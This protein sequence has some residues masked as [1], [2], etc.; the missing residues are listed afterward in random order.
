MWRIAKGAQENRS[1]IPLMTDH[2]G[3][4]FI[5]A[6]LQRSKL[7]TAE[8]FK[9]AKEQG[10]SIALVQEPYVGRNGY[11]KD[12]PG[13]Q[14]IQ[15]TLNRQKPVKAAVVVFGDK[16]EVIHD[17]QLVTETEAAVFLI[18][19]KL[20]LGVVSVYFEGNEDIEPY[21]ARTKA[22]CQKIP[23]Q[24]ILVGGDVN[25][26]SHWWGSR[27]E[28]RRGEAY[29]DFLN[30]MD[31]E[32][33][34]EG[35]TPTFETCRGDRLCTSV[36]DVTACSQSLLG[37]V[38][39]WRVNRGLTTSDHNAI[40]FTLRLEEH[41]ESLRSTST[42]RYNTKKAKWSQ[43]TTQFRTALAEKN[44]TPQVIS[45]LKTK[46]NLEI[47]IEAYMKSIREACEK[48][49]PK[50]GKKKGKAN[51]PWWT[52]ALEEQRKDVLRKKRR[53][54]N[55]APTRI[56]HVYETY[57]LAKDRYAEMAEKAQTNSWKELCSTQEKESMWDGIYRV[58][59]KTA[60][61]REEMLLRSAA[62]ETLSPAQSAQLLA[63]TFYPDDSVSTDKPC[64]T[65][66]RE[67]TEGRKVEEIEGL[68]EDD[69]PFTETE[70]ESV[71]QAQN[72]K[73][74]PGADGFTAD[75][76]IMAIR[77]EKEVFMALANKCLSLTHFPS[78]W[79]TA[80]VII[81]RKPGK[82]DYT[83]PKSYRPIGL[84]SVLGKIV[85]KLM[86][87]RLQ[88]H[89]L[90]TLNSRQ[91]GFTPQRGTEDALY[92][93]MRHVKSEVENRKIVIIVS[94]DIEGAFDNAWWP[95]LK[96]QLRVRKCPRNLY[97]M[98]DSYLSD[99][100]IVV[101]YARAASGK[102]TTKGCVQ[103]S[104]GG[105]TFWNI[106]LDP[107][108]QKLTG[109]GV[110]CQA[111]ADD[112][113][114]VF[115]DKAVSN[116][117]E[118]INETLATVVDWG[119]ENKLNFA[120][121]KTNAML[122]TKKLKFDTPTLHMSGS[123]LS[124]V[125]EIK[126]LGLII[127]R[128]L[129]FKPHVT[130]VCKKAAD[131]YKQLACAAKVTWGLNGEI[132]RTIYVAVIEP[133]V[134][135]AASAWSQA[136][137]LQMII[138]RLNALQRGFAQ[139]ICKAYRTVSLTS[140]LVLSGL[141]PLD[142]R[143][144][145]AASLYK[146]KKGLTKDYLP[147]GRELEKR[148]NYLDFPHPS[149]LVSTEYELIEDMNDQILED[150]HVAG[151]CIYTDGSKIDGNVG[152]ACTWWNEGMES[153]HALYSLHPSCTVFQSEM[154]AL[155][156]AVEMV[157]TNRNENVVTIL[158]DSRS[159]LDLL[160]N[161]KS[162]H[163]LSKTIKESIQQ[164]RAEGRQVRLCWLRAHVGTAGNERADE[165]AKEAALQASDAPDYD[166]VP[167]SYVKRKI[168][169]ES[170]RKWQ[171]RYDFSSTGSVTKVFF[172]NVD[173]AYRI[174]RKTK[175]TPRHVQ[176]LTGHGGM[177]EYLHRFKLCSSPG[178]ECDPEIIESV[179]HVLLE[180][181]RFSAARRE[182]EIQIDTTL[183]KSELQNI[184]AAAEKRPYFLEFV[185]K[186]IRTTSTRTSTM[187]PPTPTTSDTT[188]L[189]Q[190]LPAV[191]R[192]HQTAAAFE[193]LECGERGEP[194]LR[195]RG[196]ATFMDCNSEK[197]GICFCNARAPWAV[198]ISPGLASL[199][200]GSTFR[201]TMKKKTYEALPSALVGSHRC[202]ILRT[203][204]K[205]IALFEPSEVDTEFARACLLLS[206][207]GREDGKGPRR[208]SVD[209]MVVGYE[210]GEV[211]DYMGAVRASAY[212]EV[213]MYEDRGQD[214]SFLKPG[215]LA[216][217]KPPER[218]GDPMAHHQ[219]L[220]GSAR[221][222]EKAAAEE[223]AAKEEKV[224]QSREK[225][226]ELQSKLKNVTEALSKAVLNIPEV[227]RTKVGRLAEA[228]GMAAAVER[229]TKPRPEKVTS[230]KTRNI[231][232]KAD[233][234]IVEPPSLRRVTEPL[235]H[236]VNAFLEY[237][238][239]IVATKLVNTMTCKTIM[240]AYRRKNEGLLQ[241]LL[242]EAEAAV[243]DNRNSQVLKGE[244]RGSYMAAYSEKGGFVALDEEETKRRGR[245]T[246]EAP[247]DDPE[248]VT[249]KCTK[250]ML[251]DRILEMAEKISG[252]PAE[253]GVFAHWAVPK[254]TWVNGVPGCGKTTWVIQNFDVKRDLIITNTT[255]AAL[256]L[257]EKLAT[258]TNANVR[259]A[260][261]T[262]ASIL[263]NG[264]RS[265]EKY[266]RLLVDEALM[267]HFGAIVMA[268]RAA[269]VSETLLIGDN[270][271]LPF[272][273]RNNLFQLAYSQPNL[274][275]T[276]DH[277]LLC[278]HRNPMDVAYA[279][280][281]IYKGI[282]S[283]KSQVRSLSLKKYTGAEI[284]NAENTLYLAFTQAEK[285]LLISRG[286]GEK[287]GS[288]TLTIHEAQALTFERVVI[289]RAEDQQLLLHS[290]V[291]HAVVAISRHTVDCVYYTDCVEDA[292]AGLITKAESAA[293]SKIRDQN[294]RMAIR[295]RD[296]AVI[297]AM[298]ADK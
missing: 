171:D 243:Y 260:V 36:V 244:M 94:L 296:E 113:V 283:S 111:F 77:S 219:T 201:A 100:K 216:A 44:I 144:Q 48:A 123:V 136:T 232:T 79:K 80:H 126:L 240:Q 206:S 82:E 192:I 163:P 270:N 263:V 242:E 267:N 98:V 133:I 272:I 241:V 27:S 122:L 3:L 160:R 207:W 78:Q 54:K 115:S 261:R 45:E 118:F 42:R 89:I 189:T 95:A 197:L 83:Q 213:V 288:R 183:V 269:G 84:L 109:K 217:S 204:G 139:K 268:I 276:I 297:T 186:A 88:W 179:W 294:L 284:P 11:M 38:E 60:K 2:G 211:R 166:G 271:Q 129:T 134:T 159:S 193:L 173:K 99:R 181:P 156:R 256:D 1:S 231:R 220:S 292:I 252:S 120:A 40:A 198:T 290:S 86:V 117:E 107:L 239:I 102:E 43:F 131:I 221:A 154:Y 167:V 22:I 26:W 175:L 124:L 41:L 61:R 69:P 161:P 246:F 21:L 286:Y 10:V 20:K 237:K 85:E 37:K 28:D 19:G 121:H 233:K 63:E 91:Y 47:Q 76:C 176:A 224:L 72:P 200:K 29:A 127:D 262:M 138:D 90:P 194:G 170:V 108:L 59:R 169:E 195:L 182:L 18:A 110:Y 5:Q 188:Q 12:T 97:A 205:T 87:C 164:I 33:L 135:Y 81:L 6:N 218:L 287:T 174:V 39:N 9:A 141:L 125:D 55:A 52:E 295:N 228:E 64:H 143:V 73:K 103:G 282:Y 273:E 250:I 65:Q 185:E 158:S 293:T 275:A 199:L 229:F 67:L 119:V 62:G 112:V 31:Y 180:C 190:P 157:K 291:P 214:L 50:V 30:E 236:I 184:M 147:A 71:L 249:A 17:P 248:V 257:R 226:S 130:A 13:T 75:I 280:K 215:K 196:V 208:V 258:R 298:L 285:E 151:P 234:G 225:T 259:R 137:E 255:Q 152:A 277:E 35:D 278:T 92:D 203:R 46:E 25:A 150:H 70:L 68:S 145:E 15:C 142:L 34:N 148:V 238:A 266:T 202:R 74:S 235:D 153:S 114:L 172:P 212:H 32:I 281:D 162:T 66:I 149:K 96:N 23:T 51:P 56:Q 7:A 222:Q 58:I 140:A 132:V 24:N 178:C 265:S 8:M 165:L 16:V 93:L 116:M 155:H 14:V 106:I 191:P 128:K 168:R 177:A 274:V 279:L 209:A 289:V 264:I 104:I 105:P 146:S 230:K 253:G 223:Q 49:I 254:I 57:K 187:T 247:T 245:L 251:D 4:H 53:I 227:I 101:N 210:K